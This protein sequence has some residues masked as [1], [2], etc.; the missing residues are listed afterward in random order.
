MTTTVPR[1]PR[2]P[3]RPRRLTTRIKGLQGGATLLTVSAHSR[4]FLGARGCLAPAAGENRAMPLDLPVAD[5]PARG[6]GP[7]KRSNRTWK[8][9][10]VLVLVH[11]AIAAHVLHWKLT[12]RTLT[13]LEPSEA[14]QTLTTGVLNAGFV[15]LALL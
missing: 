5:A 8:R 3:S 11:G 10:L 12:G 4:P 2:A 14:G 7:V 6:C 15:V 1:A 9:A 13:P